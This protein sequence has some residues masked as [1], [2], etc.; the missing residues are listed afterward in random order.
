MIMIDTRKDI[1]EAY[2]SALAEHLAEHDLAHNVT[3]ES[4]TS[5]SY[6]NFSTDRLFIEAD[7]NLDRI[8][9]LLKAS[10]DHFAKYLADNFTSYDGFWS[11]IDNTPAL[12]YEHLQELK[13]EYISVALRFCLEL[14]HNRYETLDYTLSIAAIEDICLS[15]YLESIQYLQDGEWIEAKI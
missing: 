13:P 14:L 1:C 2:T 3:M 4:M 12:F 6:Y 9:E 8:N 5:P 11:F 10:V 15:N 7:I